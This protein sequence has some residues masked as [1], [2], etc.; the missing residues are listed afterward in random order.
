MK[1]LTAFILAI[2]TVLAVTLAGCK[3]SQSPEDV[4]KSYFA[5]FKA[6]DTVTMSKLAFTDSSAK[7]S[8]ASSASSSSLNDS[9][10][11][12]KAIAEK[13][14]TEIEGNAKID[15][16]TATVKAKIT[17][18]DTKKIL[19]DC[20]TKEISSAFSNA[21]SSSK[22]SSDTNA[23][24]DKMFKDEITQKD[25]SL[26]TTEM[27]VQ[28]VK[29]DDQWKVKITDNLSDALV[30]GMIGYLKDLSKNFSSSSN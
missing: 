25:A 19:Q 1:K 13:L 27:N 11:I 15:G 16:D 9:K 29:K 24:I 30:G 12:S 2:C 23:E 21:F 17:A 3:S 8:S 14:E 20:F 5:A 22:S 4:L 10:E 7:S 28:L 26:T 6:Q 18:P